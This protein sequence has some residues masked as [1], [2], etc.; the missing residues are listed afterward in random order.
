MVKELGICHLIISY[1]LDSCWSW[2]NYECIINRS[3]QKPAYLFATI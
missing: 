2:S 3:G 1:L